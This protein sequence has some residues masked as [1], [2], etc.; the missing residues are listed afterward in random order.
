M[1]MGCFRGPIVC[2]LSVVGLLALC[3][4]LNGIRPIAVGEVFY[5]LVKRALCFQLHDSISFHRSPQ[6]FGVVIIGGC[7]VMVHNTR[8]ALDVHTDWVVL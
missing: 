8:I 3:K 6:Y 5:Q 2:V 1:V 7:G 4:L